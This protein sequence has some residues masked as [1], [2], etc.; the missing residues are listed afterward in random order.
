[1]AAAKNAECADKNY[2]RV[3]FQ[4]RNGTT[5]GWQRGTGVYA[6]RRATAARRAARSKMYE[7][8]T[9]RQK[10]ASSASGGLKLGAATL[11]TTCCSETCS[12]RTCWTT[13]KGTIANRSVSHAQLAG[14]ARAMSTRTHA[15][16]AGSAD[17]S[18][19]RGRAWTI[20][21]GEVQRP[22]SCARIAARCAQRSSPDCR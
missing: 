4:H 22:I 16:S 6:A 12:T 5:Q 1:M 20:T 18:S 8:S 14:S 9:T 3:R 11:A 19:S 15:P 2:H 17:T 21:S 10:T 7:P 13:R